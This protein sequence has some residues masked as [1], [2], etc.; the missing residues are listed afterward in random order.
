[1]CLDDQIITSYLDNELSEPWKAQFEEHIS[2]CPA[3]KQRV[4]Q[5]QELK[6]R[7]Q[8]AVLEDSTI[9]VSQDRVSKYLEKNILNSK[10][11]TFKH[12]VKGLPAK[13]PFWPMLAA[14]ITFCF[15]LIVFPPQ[16][17]NPVLME[18]V[19][20]LTL[21]LENITQVRLSDNYTTSSTLSNY[22]LEEILQYL[23]SS[24]YD[25]QV[26]VKGL[27]PAIPV[28]PSPVVFDSFVISPSMSLEAS[29]LW[30]M[31]DFSE[32]QKFMS[33]NSSTDKE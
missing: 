20:P 33:V 25:V 29:P 30:S 17:K 27:A 6:R 18:T 26:S 32:L 14:A 4:E 11:R 28:N 3:C 1:M 24:G 21:D 5:L 13:K 15:C 10:R 2:W 12:L 9:K 19:A 7:T 31:V 22:S 23:D 8:S 16:A